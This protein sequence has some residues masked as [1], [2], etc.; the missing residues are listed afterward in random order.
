M[1]F[2]ENILSSFKNGIYNIHASK[3][4][5]DKGIS[6]VLWA[7]A[8]GD[9]YIWSTIYKMDE[10]LDSGPILK[11]I[12]IFVIPNDT[13]FS[14]YK[15]VCVESGS[16]LNVSL[17]NIYNN[18]IK[19]FYQNNELDSNYFSWPDKQFKSMMKK[20]NRKFIKI[21]DLFN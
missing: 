5:K 3:L 18:Q 19:L 16:A 21:K 17:N 6:P 1:L 8:R 20:S 9:Q 15:R 2:K 7:F 11:Q 4:P 14:L 13:S 10:G 12:Q